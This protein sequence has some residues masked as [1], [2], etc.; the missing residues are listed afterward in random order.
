MAHAPLLPHEH[1]AR[2]IAYTL[3]GGWQVLVGRTDA[4]NDVL[5]FRVARPDDWWFHV[6]GMPGSHVILRAHQAPTPIA[7]PSNAPRRSPR[8][9]IKRATRGSWRSRARAPGTSP[10]LVARQPAPCTSAMKRCL[11]CA[12]RMATWPGTLATP[13]PKPR[14]WQRTGLRDGGAGRRRDAVAG[15]GQ[16]ARRPGDLLSRALARAPGRA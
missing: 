12:R 9:T 13:L 8:T 1:S 14:S 11:R 16:P 7:R 6:R 4:D 10:S 5:S 3:P 15:H 2:V